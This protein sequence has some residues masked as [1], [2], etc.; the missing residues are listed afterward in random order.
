MDL[1][2]MLKM[3]LTFFSAD[4]GT[5]G[6]EEGTGDPAP[7]PEPGGGEQP[8]GGTGEPEPTPEEKTFTQ[9]DV[10]KIA[11]KEARK[12]QEKLFK[13]LGIEDFENAKEGFQKFQEWQESQKTEAE[14]QSEALKT[15]EKDK[16]TLSSEVNTLRAQN[17]A[18]KA[19]VKAESADDVV[20]IAERLVTDDVTIDDAI[21][22]V[23]E[24]YPQFAQEQPGEKEEKPFFST[25]QHQKKQETELEKWMNAFK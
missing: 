19:G 24:K 3:N 11:T 7:T 1:L 17:A 23:I 16:E 21:N 18:L 6:G 20:A 25:G 22:Q 13:E 2:E 9:E 15:L 12:A 8:Q 10:N 14:K 4:G 5:A